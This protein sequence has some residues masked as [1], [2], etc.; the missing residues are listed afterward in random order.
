MKQK[1]GKLGFSGKLKKEW[2]KEILTT[3]RRVRRVG[4]LVSR[5]SEGCHHGVCGVGGGISLAHVLEGSSSDPHALVLCID[6]EGHSRAACGRRHRVKTGMWMFSPVDGVDILSY[7]LDVDNNAN[8]ESPRLQGALGMVEWGT[9]VG[10]SVGSTRQ[11]SDA[12]PQGQVKRKAGKL[13]H[14]DDG[15]LIG[16]R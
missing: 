1:W 10:G 12:W 7:S 15:N 8:A 4:T 13:A 11:Q 14:S 6:G 16:S 2:C 5:G 9:K 3:S